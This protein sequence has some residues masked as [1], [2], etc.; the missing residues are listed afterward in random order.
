MLK[1]NFFFRN[2]LLVCGFV[3]LLSLTQ[4][5]KVSG[6][7]KGTSGLENGFHQMYNLDF[8]GAHK[9]F[10]TW[11]ELHPEDPLGPAS[12]AAAY[13]FSEFERLH[14]LE[15]DFF[16]DKRRFS[17][18]EQV[19]PDP[20]IKAAF[21]G[22][23]SKADDIAGKILAENANNHDA[24]F[25]KV[26]TDGLRGNYAALVENQKLAALARLKASRT[27][28]EKLISV[29]PDYHDA[30][31][32]IGIENYI[33]GIRSMPSRFLLRLSGAQTNKEKGIESLQITAT[34]GRFLAPY[35]RL[36]LAI[37]AMRDRDQDT[38][39]TLLTEL[40]KEFPRN[41]LFRVELARLES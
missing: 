13:L 17:D 25:A 32:A 27:T 23:L 3:L 21:E 35:A 7:D 29:D 2:V 31:L 41:R 20:K 38:A 5:G 6:V 39:R 18:R 9:T 16:T 33:L 4:Y 19:P 8:K 11:Q 15:L 14:V 37:A 22:E 24:L 28:A 36:L 1:P 10:E 26:L 12:N 34:K 30:Y 40:A